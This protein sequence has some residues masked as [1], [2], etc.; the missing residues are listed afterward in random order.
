M[1]GT[2]KPQWH[3]SIPGGPWPWLIAAVH[4]LVFAWIF[5]QLDPPVYD[6]A[7]YFAYGILLSPSRPTLYGDWSPMLIYFVKC[8]YWI[9][10]L[11]KSSLFA[12]YSYLCGLIFLA[13]AYSFVSAF[14]NH[15]AWAFWVTVMAGIAFSYPFINNGYKFPAGM[16]M[17]AMG[18]LEREG[19]ICVWGACAWIVFAMLLRMEYLIVAAGLAALYGAKLVRTGGTAAF[20]RVRWG[21]VAALL[22]MLL[23][24]APVLAMGKLSTNRL[25]FAFGEK[26]HL[27]AKESGLLE[28]AGLPPDADW[29]DTLKAFFPPEQRGSGPLADAIPLIGFYRANPEA[30]N[31]FVWRNFKP[32]RQGVFSFSESIAVS[33]FLSL[34]TVLSFILL[35]YRLAAE[36]RA[37][38]FTPLWITLVF[39]LAALPTLFTSTNRVY[40]LPALVWTIGVLPGY[41]LAGAPKRHWFPAAL[42]LTAALYQWPAWK[43][44]LLSQW[45]HLGTKRAAA[46][47]L[48]EGQPGFENCMVAE[49]YPYFS[50]AFGDAVRDSCGYD[51]RW[52]P[53]RRLY[54]ADRPGEPVGFVLL[55]RPPGNHR[56]ER[57]SIQLDEWMRK[58]GELIAERGGFGV[59]R[60]NPLQVIVTDTPGD[61]TDLCLAEDVDEPDN[62]GLTL[63]WFIPES[64]YREFHIWVSVDGGER[65]YL[66]IAR[67]PAAREFEWTEGANEFAP[68]FRGGPEFGK[69]YEFTVFGIPEAWTGPGGGSEGKP[70]PHYTAGPVF[71]AESRLE[72]SP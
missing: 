55:E 47:E 69:R 64:G 72:D 41:W 66:G 43:D 53:D 32:F 13:G 50:V 21:S 34:L 28:P 24:W 46:L 49:A 31:G 39:A 45:P 17:L 33:S 20:F 2:N 62:R 44:H 12:L 1:S 22:V 3:E 56:F 14:A 25:E 52:G 51:V 70:E 30:F 68:K 29:R 5:P 37:E 67:D 35:L 18:Q 19:K 61:D 48:A 54:P 26:F 8:L 40:I 27:Y 57:L 59:W 11:S 9:A 42:A 38:L 10:P 36:R 15:R 58:F 23:A 6:D 60:V 7:N 71:F 65:E 63:K 16:L 4:T